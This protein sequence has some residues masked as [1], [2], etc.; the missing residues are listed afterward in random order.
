MWW[1]WI[2]KLIKQPF[3]LF[4]LLHE[5]V[6]ELPLQLNLLLLLSLNFHST[7]EFGHELLILVVPA[8][9]LL[10]QG[11][12]MLDLPQGQSSRALKRTGVKAS[13]ALAITGAVAL[14]TFWLW[15]EAEVT[16]AFVDGRPRILVLVDASTIGGAQCAGA[17]YAV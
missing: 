14:V 12:A 10:L 4:D 17:R 15:L 1:R 2:W 3:C 7:Y 6:L 9:L 11:Q 16:L 13:R 5:F 8:L